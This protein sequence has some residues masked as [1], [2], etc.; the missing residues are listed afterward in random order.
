MEDH[1]ISVIETEQWMHQQ[2][3]SHPGEW[4]EIDDPNH[5]GKYHWIKKKSR[6]SSGQEYTQN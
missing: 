5:P 4:I 2:R 6:S 1:E 3:K